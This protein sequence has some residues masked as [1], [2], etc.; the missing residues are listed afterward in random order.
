M[1]A[2]YGYIDGTGEYYI[3][4]DSDKCNGCGDCVSACPQSLLE[5]YEDDYEEMVV[6]VKEEV[7]KKLGYLCPGSAAGQGPDGC[8]VACV[9]ACPSEV[10]EHSW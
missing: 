7:I 5:V 1:K 2:Q 3:T 4:V 8:K 6:R 9:A 10:F